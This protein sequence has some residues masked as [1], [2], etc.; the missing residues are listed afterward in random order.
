MPI[1]DVKITSSSAV[2][3]SQDTNCEDPDIRLSRSWLRI[4]IAMVFAGQGMVFSLAINMTPPEY[5]STSYWLLHGGL[6]FSSLLVI[7]FLGSPLIGST[8]RMVS[9]RRLSI[10]GLFTVSLLGAFTGSLLCTFTGEGAVYYEIV[11]IVIAIYTIG[12]LLSG[13]A[14]SRLGKETIQ[15][16]ESFD[17]ASMRTEDGWIT[18]KVKDVPIGAIVRVQP[19]EPI[20]VDGTICSGSAY[21]SETALTGEALPVVR[22]VGDVVRAGTWSVDGLLEIKVRTQAGKRDLDDLLQRV[23]D[24]A[25]SSSKFES[26]ANRLIQYFLPFVVITSILC[27]IYWLFIGSWIEA[28]F[29][30]MAVL[31]VAC[32][33]ALGLATPIGI[34]QGLLRLAKIGIVSRDGALIDALAT[35][36]LVYFDKTGTLSDASMEVTNFTVVKEWEDRYESL[37][38]M[39]YT[40]ESKL[41]HP[42]ARSITNFLPKSDLPISNFKIIPG[43]GVTGTIEKQVVEIGEL[44][45]NTKLVKSEFIAKIVGRKGKPIYVFI[46]KQLAAIFIIK[47]RL[48]DGISRLEEGFKKLNIKVEVLTGDRNPEIE[49]P[50]II[51]FGLSA[52]QKESHIRSA[53]RNGLDPLFV[54]DGINDA[55]AMTVSMASISMGSG[56]TLAR[57]IANGHLVNDQISAL[58]EAVHFSRALHRRLRSNLIY[59]V[60]Y[61]VLGMSLAFFGVLHPIVAALIMALS[62]F[63]VTI[64]ATYFKYNYNSN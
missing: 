60:S 47:E 13:V 16:R 57:S 52:Q 36:R 10:E 50:F 19:G 14:Q 61:N 1:A 64:R 7:C 44:G 55:P 58:P 30:S 11:S 2:C 23:D 53:I 59:A 63:M 29:N 15:I 45:F 46:D 9:S 41:S 62:S 56:T 24:Q 4:A 40:L 27:L 26:Q 42:I 39:I 33:C 54:G 3:S 31:L 43:L 20:S 6:I 28:V 5:G 32:P 12:R 48:R 22:D 34:W 17:T 35:T 38:S 8:I 37:Q 25:S 51:H 18:V 49:L 21:V